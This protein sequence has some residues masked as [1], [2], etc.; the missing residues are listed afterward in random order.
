MTLLSCP[1][2]CHINKL[3]PTSLEHGVTIV[4]KYEI[5]KLSLVGDEQGEKYNT[6]L[7][8][9]LNRLREKLIG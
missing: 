3:P 2:L 1:I 5:Q 6:P 4:R 8:C 9:F 7:H